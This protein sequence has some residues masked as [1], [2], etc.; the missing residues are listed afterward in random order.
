MEARTFEDHTDRVKNA[1]K[2]PAA[3]RAV[4]RALVVN[5][6]FDLVRFAAILAAI[7]VYRHGLTRFATEPYPTRSV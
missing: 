6:V 2:M 3:R 7:F 1:N 5:A 4:F